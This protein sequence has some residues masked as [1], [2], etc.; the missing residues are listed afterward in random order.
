MARHVLEV[1]LSR[2]RGSGFDGSIKP[3]AH[4]GST[5]KGKKRRAQLA[6]Q[7]DDEIVFRAANLFEQSEKRAHRLPFAVTPGKVATRK[8]TTSDSAG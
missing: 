6:V 7:I 2:N 3:D 8:S 4:L 1:M 5:D